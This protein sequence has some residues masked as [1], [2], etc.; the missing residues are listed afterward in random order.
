MPI[1]EYVCDGCSRSFSIIKL[2]RDEGGPACPVCGSNQVTKQFSTFSC[3]SGSEV[4]P[5]AGGFGG[6]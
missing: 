4:G 6:G 5:S 1:F 2:D 3:P